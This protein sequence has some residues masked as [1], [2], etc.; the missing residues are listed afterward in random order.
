MKLYR[1]SKM[2]S[3]GEILSKCVE[4]K[5]QD[6]RTTTYAEIST[7]GGRANAFKGVAHRIGSHEA[8]LKEEHSILGLCGYMVNN[9]CSWALVFNEDKSTYVDFVCKPTEN[10]GL[11]LLSVVVVDNKVNELIE[12]LG[13]KI[14]MPDRLYLNVINYEGIVADKM[15][16]LST[17]LISIGNST[18]LE[19]V[20][21]HVY[22]LVNDLKSNSYCKSVSYASD[23]VME[24]PYTIYRDGELIANEGVLY[25]RGL[26]L[27]S[28]MPFKEH[29]KDSCGFAFSNVVPIETNIVPIGKIKSVKRYESCTNRLAKDVISKLN[30]LPPSLVG[31]NTFG[32]AIEFVE[33]NWG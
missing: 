2:F 3:V 1:C 14:K 32:S 33:K 7:T 30:E 22:R 21:G 28:H 11:V 24:M 18:T 19:T 23:V 9:E 13:E 27:V 12:S 5:I 16:D 29:D 6:V 25:C 10:D 17:E 31:D 15:N 4:Y 26:Y 20:D 8:E